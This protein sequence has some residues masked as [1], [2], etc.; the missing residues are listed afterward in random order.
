MNDCFNFVRPC[1]FFLAIVLEDNA[2]LKLKLTKMAMPRKEYVE[3]KTDDG[4][5]NYNLCN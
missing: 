3:V 4:E 5:G 2:N 1:A